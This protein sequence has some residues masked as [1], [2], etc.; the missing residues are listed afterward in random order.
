MLRKIPLLAAWLLC[1]CN[2]SPDPVQA[3]GHTDQRP[4]LLVLGIAQ[5]A[6]YPQAGC[7][8]ACCRK[9]YEGKER[10]HF[11]SCIALVSP[12]DS[13]YWL[14]D[15]TPDLPAQVHLLDSLTHLSIKSL[16]GIFLT[17]AHIG[18]YTGLMYFGRE[19]MNTKKIPVYCMPDMHE[20]LQS[21]GPW[22]QLVSLQNIE[23]VPMKE[24]TAVAI[25]RNMTV[26]SFEVPHRHEY[27]ETAGFRISTGT[28]SAVFIPDIDKWSKWQKSILD[29][30][31]QN[32]LALIDGTFYSSGEIPG[33]NM[34]EVP[35]PFIGESVKLFENLSA[36]EKSR[37]HFIHL[38]HT[39]PALGTA[40]KEREEIGRKGFSVCTEGERLRF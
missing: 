20:F 3:V 38:N 14:F 26:T 1:S 12:A 33:R 32:D 11:V 27:T 39:N 40:S 2:P 17:H 16:A 15:C 5:D 21:N 6:G 4:Y 13:L 30:I 7:T 19:S 35:H 9:Y 10:K 8:K 22:N 28:G 37:V 31:R 29:V 34:D 24:D 23:L 36:K 25:G 18:H